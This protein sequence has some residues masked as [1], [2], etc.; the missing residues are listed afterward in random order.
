MKKLIILSLIFAAATQVTFANNN[1]VNP[2][3][4]ENFELRK[5]VILRAGTLVMMETTERI[6]SD[7]VTVGKMIRFKVTTNVYAEGRAVITTGALAIGRVKSKQETTFNDPAEITIELTSVQSVDGQQI[8]LNGQ[9]QIY[10]G[11]FSG[12]GT[13]VENGMTITATVTNDVTIKVN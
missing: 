10:Q 5:K 6:F 1:P 4:Y 8:P 12:E 3:A 9:E 13:K 2:V 11:Q 7:D